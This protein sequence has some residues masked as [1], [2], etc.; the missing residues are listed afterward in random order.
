VVKQTVAS[1]LRSLASL[2]LLGLERGWHYQLHLRDGWCLGLFV[3]LLLFRIPSSGIGTQQFDFFELI[4][5]VFYV[6]SLVFG[7]RY[8]SVASCLIV[9]LFFLFGTT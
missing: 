6:P 8:G 4:R 5:K 3:E 1:S 2:L 7:R 9:I